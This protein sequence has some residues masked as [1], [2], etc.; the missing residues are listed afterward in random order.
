SKKTIHHPPKEEGVFLEILVKTHN[1]YLKV[2]L[3]GDNIILFRN[4]IFSTLFYQPKFPQPF[5]EQSPLKSNLL[6][7]SKQA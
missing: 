6:S 3:F 5:K 4:N 7:L 2:C 1:L